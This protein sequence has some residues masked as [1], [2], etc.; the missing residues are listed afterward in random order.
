MTVEQRQGFDTAKRALLDALDYETRR[1]SELF[2]IKM[3][4]IVLFV[5][6]AIITTFVIVSGGSMQDWLHFSML[7]MFIPVLFLCVAA[8]P[9]AVYKAFARKRLIRISRDLQKEVRKTVHVIYRQLTIEDAFDNYSMIDHVL[10]IHSPDL[11]TW[12][13]EPKKTTVVIPTEKSK[14]T[15]RAVATMFKSQAGLAIPDAKKGL[16]TQELESL[17]AKIKASE[18]DITPWS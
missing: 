6:L 1:K 5:L 17:Y 16:I 4:V 13:S 11:T 7:F 10:A 15:V 8:V 12:F 9:F 3:I 18:S 2:L 14:S